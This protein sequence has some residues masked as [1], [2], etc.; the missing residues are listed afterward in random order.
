MPNFQNHKPLI[1]FVVLCQGSKYVS[2]VPMVESPLWRRP[3]PFMPSTWVN[4]RFQ[5]CLELSNPNKNNNN[6]HVCG[7]AF[8]LFKFSELGEYHS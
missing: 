7:L 5:P 2:N 8:E 4:S 1:P 6:S 3:A